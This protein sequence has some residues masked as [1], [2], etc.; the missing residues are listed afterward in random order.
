M[1]QN[2]EQF[3]ESQRGSGSAEQTGRE[4]NEQKLP[5]SDLGNEQRQDIADQIGES[6]KNISSI[7]QT[8]GLSGRDDSGG[9][10]GY[11]KENES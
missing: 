4:R 5:Q 7:S 2:K 9:G 8:G 6:R 11:R 3:Q 10:S 1:A